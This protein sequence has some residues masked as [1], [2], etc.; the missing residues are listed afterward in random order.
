[1]PS[2]I[3][4]I[5]LITLDLDDT[6]WPC[7]AVIQNA[8]EQLYAWLEREAARITAR[9]DLLSL[10]QHRLT[11]AQETPELAH[12]LTQLRL[13]SLRRLLDQEG[14]DPNAA[15]IAMSVFLTARNQV[16][17]YPEVATTLAQLRP[18]YQLVALT[19]GNADVARTP[20]RDCFHFSLT[21]AEAGAAKPDPALFHGAL[22]RAGVD[23]NQALHVGDDPELD[24]AAAQAVGMRAVWLN[25][26]G[27]LWPNQQ[28]P[29]D[30]SLSS[31]EQLLDWLTDAGDSRPQ[32]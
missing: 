12:D 21:A 3:R 11:L 1:M 29:P 18:H 24:V 32:P 23:A 22:A 25:R 30:V 15:E 16:T 14:Y 13:S 31:L 28:P 6:L 17:P 8:E 2:S 9:H 4:S 20:L 10:R 7:A 27:H 26:D 19:N 5:R